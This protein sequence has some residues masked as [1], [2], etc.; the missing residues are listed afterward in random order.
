MTSYIISHSNPSIFLSKMID[1]ASSSSSFEYLDFKNDMPDLKYK[2]LLI[3]L[4]LDQFGFS[5]DIYDWISMMQNT[6][7]NPFEGSIAGLLIR[8]QGDLYTKTFA[9]NIIFHMNQ[10]GCAF[11]GHPLVEAIGNLRNFLTMQKVIKK[12]LENVCLDCCKNL[13][14]RLSDFKSIGFKNPNIVVLHS[15]NEQKSNTFKYWNMIKSYLPFDDIHEIHIE[16][17]TVRDCHGCPFTM[18]LHYGKQKSCFYG[19][20]MV[21]EVYPALLNADI[22][23]LLCPNYNDALTANMSAVINRLTALYRTTKFYNKIFYAVVVSGNSGSDA[24]AKQLISALNMNKSFT[25]PPYFVA[26][27]TANDYNAILNVPNIEIHSKEFAE[28]I[29]SNFNDFIF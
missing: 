14:K 6:S 24:L 20:I 17:G 23:I 16:N 10:M 2:R 11:I 27:A 26:M 28:I 29:Q 25:L 3:A 7:K 21:D 1:A 22:L 8:G 18:C 19:G 12:P 9:Q 15:S 4:D 13:G 5:K